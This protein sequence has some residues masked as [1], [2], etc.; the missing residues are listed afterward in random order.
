MA[1]T[2]SSGFASFALILLCLFSKSLYCYKNKVILVS[3]DGFRHDYLDIAKSEGLD[4]SAL[5]ALYKRGFR[6]RVVPI[7]PTITFPTHFSTATGRYAENHGIMANVFYSPEY[8]ASFSYRNA[9]DASDSR[10]WNYNDNEPIW[11]TNERHGDRKSCVF[12]WPGSASSYA[13]KLPTRTQSPYN[14]SIDFTTRIDQ[15]LEWMQEDDKIS[16]CMVYMEE[17]DAS[18]HHFGPNSREVKSKVEELNFLVKYLIEK[19][20]AMPRMSDSV[21]VVLTSDHGMA[22]VLDQNI[23]P[24]YNIL[25]PKDYIANPSRVFFGIWP[26]QGGPTVTQMY[27]KLVKAN[28]TGL[29]VYL[30][31]DVPN[32]YHYAGTPRCPP[33]ILLADPKYAILYQPSQRYGRGEHGYDNQDTRMHALLI[34]AGPNVRQLDDVQEIQQIDIYA[35]I[36]GI[37][38]L[39]MPNEI[40]GDLR[41]VARLIRPPPT[42]EFINQFMFYSQNSLSTDA[43]SSNVIVK[44]TAFIAFT[45]F[46]IG[47]MQQFM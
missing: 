28:V 31:K 9:F 30:K 44:S 41:R 45:L 46:M 39:Q 13:S 25:D 3:F 6:G 8:N 15:I 47:Y 2:S 18:G 35:L 4:I 11:M 7:M 37:L 36:C 43:S 33:L 26:K 22:E 21:N 5:E 38:E 29:S 10:W 34:A 1:L 24:L 40:D 20:D 32:R 16:L 23:V 42:Q 17:P 19:I 12:F 27:D 14:A